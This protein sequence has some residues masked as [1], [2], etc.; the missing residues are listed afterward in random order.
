M[1][2]FYSDI[3]YSF[4]PFMRSFIEH[5]TVINWKNIQTFS[6]LFC[7]NTYLF[8]NKQGWQTVLNTLFL[9]IPFPTSQTC[10]VVKW[11]RIFITLI[12][13]L[14]SNLARRGISQKG[15]PWYSIFSPMSPAM[16]SRSW[17]HPI[18]QKPILRLSKWICTFPQ[19]G[20]YF[21]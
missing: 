1:K 15:L 12:S 8:V 20:Y 4:F 17:I 5:R 9:R 2:F 6:G 14:E 16:C 13:S 19:S 11:W 3:I 18:W 10:W 21:E 7:I